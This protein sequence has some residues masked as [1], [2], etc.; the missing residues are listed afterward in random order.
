[1]C[2]SSLGVVGGFGGG[3]LEVEGGGLVSDFAGDDGDDGSCGEL[4]AVVGAVSG[5]G[6]EGFDVDGVSD[7]GVDEGDVGVGAGGEGSFGQAEDACGVD[8]EESEEVWP[9]EDSGIDEGFDEEAQGAFEGDDA[10]GGVEEFELF[11]ALEVWCVVGDEA[12]DGSVGEAL[13]ECVAVDEGSQGG[14]HF[15]VG[16]VASASIFGEQEVV[17][18]DFGGDESA[19]GFCSSDDFDGASCGEVLSVVFC[20]GLF[21]ELDVTVEHAFFGEG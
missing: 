9:V 11:F 13:A 8:G 2:K 6:V 7:E 1:M 17:G 20:A 21:G 19:F 14:V 3:G 18:G 15:V 4:P 10:E 16:V 5:L 12:V